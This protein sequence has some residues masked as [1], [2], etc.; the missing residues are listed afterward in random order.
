MG[1]WHA[2]YPV[3]TLYVDG[4]MPPEQIRERIKG[5][6]GEK[7]ALGWCVAVRRAYHRWRRWGRT[8]VET[9]YEYRAGGDTDLENPRGRVHIVDVGDRRMSGGEHGTIIFTSSSP[10]NKYTDSA[11]ECGSVLRAQEMG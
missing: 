8:N 1:D 9:A 10:W 7:C 2:P 6:G 3:K 5:M 4:E 11:G